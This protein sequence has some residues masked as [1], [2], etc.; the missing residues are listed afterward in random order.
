MNEPLNANPVSIQSSFDVM[1][2]TFLH[3]E[4]V[5]QT[6]DDEPWNSIEAAF[7]SSTLKSLCLDFINVKYLSSMALGK[8]VTLNRRFRGQVQVVNLNDRILEI[9]RVAALDRVLMIETVQKS[10]AA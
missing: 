6:S 2:V 4:L 7:A 3:D 1:T 8:L 10:T 9:L 5:P